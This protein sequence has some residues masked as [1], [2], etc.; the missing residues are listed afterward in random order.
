MSGEHSMEIGEGG[1][2]EEDVHDVCGEVNAFLPVISQ[3]TTQCQQ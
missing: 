3:N 1:E 2:A